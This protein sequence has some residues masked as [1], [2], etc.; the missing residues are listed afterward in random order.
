MKMW[1]GLH[2]AESFK[3]SPPFIESDVSLPYSQESATGPY[4]EPDESTSHPPTLLL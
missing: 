1:A 4:P 2:E 3:K